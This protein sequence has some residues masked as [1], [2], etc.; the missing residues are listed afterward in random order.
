[1]TED[2]D[3]CNIGAEDSCVEMNSSDM[4]GQIYNPFFK[5][6]GLFSLK[7]PVLNEIVLLR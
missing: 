3:S 2:L 5:E 4:M 7:T 6:I 1:M